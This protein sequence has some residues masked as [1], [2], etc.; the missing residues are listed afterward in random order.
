MTGTSI[1]TLQLTSFA[2]ADGHADNDAA[3]NT[4]AGTTTRA[5]VGAFWLSPMTQVSITGD[6]TLDLSRDAVDGGVAFARAYLSAGK[7]LDF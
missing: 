5:S 1:E 2:S 3:T 4:A 7:T 6:L